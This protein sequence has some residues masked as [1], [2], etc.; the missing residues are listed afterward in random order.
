M[1]SRKLCILS[2]LLGIG[3]S[4]GC[5]DI[6]QD[7]DGLY[8]GTIGKIVADK[9]RCLDGPKESSSFIKSVKADPAA[10][11]AMLFYINGYATAAEIRDVTGNY[12][13]GPENIIACRDHA[14]AGKLS[15]PLTSVEDLDRIRGV[16]KGTIERLRDYAK[17][18][19]S[20][21]KICTTGPLERLSLTDAEEEAVMDYI[22]GRA[23]VEE[24]RE[25]TSNYQ[26]GPENIIACRN[27][28]F[29][30]KVVYPLNNVVDLDRI[31]KVGDGTI[32][33]LR[34]FVEQAGTRVH[35]PMCKNQGTAEE[36]WYW[37]DTGALINNEKC[38]GYG[39]DCVDIGSDWEGWVAVVPPGD[40][41]RYITADECHRTVG[42][43]LG[44]EDCADE[45]M[46]CYDKYNLECVEGRCTNEF[47]KDPA[48]CTGDDSCDKGRCIGKTYNGYEMVGVC[49]ESTGEGQGLECMSDL[50]C[51]EGTLCSNFN[52][53]K[54]NNYNPYEGFCEPL[55]NFGEFANTG[56]FDLVPGQRARKSVLAAGLSY[57]GMSA[58]LSLSIE[59]PDMDGLTVTIDP[60][61][62][63]YD[64][65]ITFK[66]KEESAIYVGGEHYQKKIEVNGD[67][68]D[69]ENNRL[70][71]ESLPINAPG[72]DH[73]NGFWNVLIDNST[74]QKGT[75][76]SFSL[77][78]S[79]RAD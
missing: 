64:T 28:R 50:T 9:A 38:A 67:N 30:G 2:I 6:Q 20:P 53:G 75:A 7:E 3:F 36:G 37:E 73:V 25:V 21:E 29:N 41:W 74:S 70:E 24:L 63:G 47:I 14:I 32:N 33:S 15:Y 22:N 31:E 58:M 61:C 57:V 34:D 43:A 48:Y 18:H 71:L 39:L 26:G 10:E 55:E 12:S 1:V 27:H 19:F 44:G 76:E 49:K 40:G 42:I 11:E 77:K 66:I 68:I 79:S 62:E 16:G 65:K 51:G 8:A 69:F 23:T 52:D 35:R 13:D 46:E 60:P 72:D 59:H 5:S 56:S 17:T 78:I 4:V 54:D 45:N